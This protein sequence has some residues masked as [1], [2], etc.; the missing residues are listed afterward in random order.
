M[1]E[2]AIQLIG[3]FE[4][5]FLTHTSVGM[6]VDW[7]VAREIDPEGFRRYIAARRYL[8]SIGAKV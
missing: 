1:R 5:R 7:M 6:A 3:V 4:S 8:L 2:T